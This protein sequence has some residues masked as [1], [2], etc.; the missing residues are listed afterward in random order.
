MSQKLAQ[1]LL[2]YAEYSVNAFSRYFDHPLPLK[3][4]DFVVIP[5]F[6]VQVTRLGG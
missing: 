3:K 1:E 6:I 4:M 5:D 2:G